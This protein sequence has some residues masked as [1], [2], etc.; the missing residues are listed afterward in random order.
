MGADFI[1]YRLSGASTRT[2]TGGISW[3]L[4]SRTALEAT[5]TKDDTTVA[6]GLDY[7]AVIF[8]LTLIHRQ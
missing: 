2:L 7:R 1:A 3:S 4:A 8:V 5:L 6:G